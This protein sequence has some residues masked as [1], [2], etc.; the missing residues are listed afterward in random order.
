[1]LP[2]LPEDLVHLEGGEDGLDEHRGLDRAGGEPEGVL[3]GQDHVVPQPRLEVAL[4]L[5]QVNRDRSLLPALR[6][7]LA[8]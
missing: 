6:A 2:Q 7:Q 1:M 3:R 4:Q 5:G 8:M